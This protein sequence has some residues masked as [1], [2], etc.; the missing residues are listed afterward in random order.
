VKDQPLRT[1]DD[2]IAEIEGMSIEEILRIPLN[3]PHLISVDELRAAGALD[4]PPEWR[5]SLSA[6]TKRSRRSMAEEMPLFAACS[7]LPSN[8][9]PSAE[10]S[11][12]KESQNAN[13]EA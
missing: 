4:C 8:V 12:S 1:I 3:R 11:E 2:I 6:G 5:R 13:D 10:E 7:A 9:P